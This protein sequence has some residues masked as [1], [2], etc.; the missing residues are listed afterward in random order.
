[1][2]V[3]DTIAGKASEAGLTIA[4]EQL[5]EGARE[6][7]RPD[8]V[9]KTRDRACVADVTV[10]FE[11]EASLREAPREKKEKYEIIKEEIGRAIG[12]EEVTVLP[13][14]LGARGAFPNETKRNLSRLGI[15][16]AEEWEKIVVGIVKRSVA[17]ARSHCD[18]A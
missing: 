3:V 6:P 16:T 9:I 18:L 7:L 2:T 12:C 11:Q 4:R 14:V 8:L 13:I 15:S 10:R 17:I 5:F 1:M